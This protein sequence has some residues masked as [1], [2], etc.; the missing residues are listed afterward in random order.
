M[1]TS[2]MPGFEREL[3]VA[4]RA[5]RS[6][7]R[8]VLDHYEQ[9]SAATYTKRDGSVVTD[10]DLA[11]DSII[12][13]ILTEAFPDDPILTEEGADNPRRLMSRR[14]WV[15]DPIDGTN[16]FVERTGEFEVLVA[17]VMDGRPVAGAM[18]QPTTDLLISASLGG[19]AWIEQHGE[20]S[21]LRFEPLEDGRAPRLMTSVWLGSPD[22]LPFLEMVSAG[23]G[24]GPAT[25]SEIGISVRRFLPPERAADSLIGY[26]VGG[27]VDGQTAAWEWDFA[28]ADIVV[29]EAGGS[30]TDIRGELHRYNKPDPR[31]IGGIVVSVDPRTHSK[32]VKGIQ[33]AI[34]ST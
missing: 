14:V 31:N 30:M 22:N 28:A 32:I 8:T 4:E 21:P 2:E 12:R 33:A 26:K 6:A 29:H 34:I 15:V 10:A 20:R 13:Q 16:Q 18:Y 1:T 27:D 9:Q 5:A 25:V 11:A 23:I 17:L 24:S 7:G 3:Q 19:G